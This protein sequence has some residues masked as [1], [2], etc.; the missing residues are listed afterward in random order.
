MRKYT[1][2]AVLLAGTLS[3]ACGTAGAD[4]DP[5]P[6]FQPQVVP[7]H[8]TATLNGA[9]FTVDRDGNSVIV[10]GDG[11]TFKAVDGSVIVQDGSGATVASLPLTYR[12]DDLV[13]PI[14]AEFG[15]HSVRMTPALSGGTPATATVT[16]GAIA[17]SQDIPTDVANAKPITE[18]FTPRDLQELQN[19][20]T[21]AWL[22]SFTGTVIGAIV[23]G[24]VGCGAGALVGSVS[25]G[26][27][28]LFA[29]LLPGAIIGCIAGVALIG[30]VGGLLGAALVAGPIGLWSAYQ[31][32][33][34][35]L[36][37]CTGPGVYCVNPAAPAPAPA[38]AA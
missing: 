13:F 15:D 14:A 8:Q 23:G 19:F 32:F 6:A 12:K 38:P 9:G 37:P 4:P 24:V 27:T 21:R 34:T 18:S 25:A 2:G 17:Q 10:A 26:V 35:I 7:S 31:Y 28:T 11:D 1:A 29:G 36:A 30:S 16:A 5:N 3:I 20:G 22:A 33:S